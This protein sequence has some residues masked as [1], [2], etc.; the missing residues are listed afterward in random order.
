MILDLNVVILSSL[1][2]GV[3]WLLYKYF[4]T[5]PRRLHNT[6]KM[7]EDIIED[8]KLENKRLKGRIRF[9]EGG[10][11]PLPLPENAPLE[12]ALTQLVSHLPRWARPIAE[13]IIDWAK[14]NPEKAQA[15]INQY[16]KKEG[17]GIGGETL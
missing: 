10:S 4:S 3:I 17:G 13:G 9:L 1:G 12:Q 15:L 16:V 5:S 2:M 8:L 11:P 14:K 7:Y 6:I